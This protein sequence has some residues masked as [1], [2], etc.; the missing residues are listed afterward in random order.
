VQAFYARL[1][2]YKDDPRK[3]KI[4]AIKLEFETLFSTVTP[5]DELNKAIAQTKKRQA[6]LLAVLKNPD[7]PLHNN[8][9]EQQIRPMVIKRKIQFGTRSED[10]R[11]SRD[12]FMS[13]SMTCKKLDLSFYHFLIDRL[14]GAKEILQLSEIIQ[15]KIAAAKTPKTG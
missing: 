14:L 3:E 15:N 8:H 6:G 2:E 12:T 11:K 4:K 9:A 10:G 5:Y 13:I 1:K 7:L